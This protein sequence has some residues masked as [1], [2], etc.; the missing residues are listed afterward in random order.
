MYNYLNLQK[1][2]EL[3]PQIYLKAGPDGFLDLMIQFSP[4]AP[5]CRDDRESLILNQQVHF[6]EIHFNG[7]C[8]DIAV[9]VVQF[10]SHFMNR[11]VVRKAHRIQ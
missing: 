7:C 3:S 10:Y 8:Q 9:D 4:L 6:A 2:H 1:S 11:P 5:P